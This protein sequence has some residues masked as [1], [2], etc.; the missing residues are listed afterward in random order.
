M[1]LPNIL[2]Q[3]YIQWGVHYVSVCFGLQFNH[4]FQTTYCIQNCEYLLLPLP[5]NDV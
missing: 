3:H 1:A 4:T 5:A 2:F